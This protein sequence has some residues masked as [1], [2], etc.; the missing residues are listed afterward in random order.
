MELKLLK[1][2]IAAFLSDE[3]GATA[4][5]YALLIAL[6]GTGLV[7]TLS[8]MGNGVDNN[9]QLLGDTIERQDLN[10]GHVD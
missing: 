10:T 5:E 4:I 6:L 1:V 3:S 9:L 2:K 7:T 8:G